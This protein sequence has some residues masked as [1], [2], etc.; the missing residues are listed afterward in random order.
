MNFSDL[1][2]Y[3]KGCYAQKGGNVYCMFIHK[4]KSYKYVWKLWV[5]GGQN[6]A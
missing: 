4:G 1:I 6:E 3:F 2:K 5:K